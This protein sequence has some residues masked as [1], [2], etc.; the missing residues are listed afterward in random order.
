MFYI[1]GTAETKNKKSTSVNTSSLTTGET[2]TG[3]DQGT[4]IRVYNFGIFNSAVVQLCKLA[5]NQ[6]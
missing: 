5:I 6:D 2:S 4:Y 3:V 1:A